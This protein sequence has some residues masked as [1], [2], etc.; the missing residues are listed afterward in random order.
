MFKDGG[1]EIA[2]FVDGMAEGAAKFYDE[3]GKE[4]DRFYKD[5]ELVKQ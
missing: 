3:N 4:E 1:R 5:G 2:Y